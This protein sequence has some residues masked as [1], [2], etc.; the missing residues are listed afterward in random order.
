MQIEA[1]GYA[2]GIHYIVFCL[3]PEYGKLLLLEIVKAKTFKVTSVCEVEYSACN[4]TSSEFVK[5]EKYISIKE[6]IFSAMP[7]CK[8]LTEVSFTQEDMP[9]K[10]VDEIIKKVRKIT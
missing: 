2:R 1:W 8:N 5:S 4:T 7:H 10:L 6:S 9:D 3:L